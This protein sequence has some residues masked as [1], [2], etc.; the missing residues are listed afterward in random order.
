[1]CDEVM[2]QQ[3][4]NQIRGHLH[5]S[6]KTPSKPLSFF[7]FLAKGNTLGF[8]ATQRISQQSTEKKRVYLL[9][10]PASELLGQDEL[11]VINYRRSIPLILSLV[12][13]V[14]VAVLVLV[15][16]MRL[17]VVVVMM[18]GP[19]SMGMGLMR[20]GGSRGELRRGGVQAT[21]RRRGGGR[22]LRDLILSH[23]DWKGAGRGGEGGGFRLASICPR[24]R[25]KE[26]SREEANTNTK[27]GHTSRTKKKREK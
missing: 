1:M 12:V 9:D 25:Y 15:L 17:L 22:G 18:L 24:F 4:N 14:L 11:S 2:E 10:D 21:S 8:V 20:G 16:V 19:T 7:L 5:V 26:E 3:A 23:G 6:T 13:V 27:G